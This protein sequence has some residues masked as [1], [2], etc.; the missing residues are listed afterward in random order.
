MNCVAIKNHIDAFFSFESLQSTMTT[1]V[2]IERSEAI[3]LYDLIFG[4]TIII[5]LLKDTCEVAVIQRY[6][7][8]VHIDIVSFFPFLSFFQPLSASFLLFVVR[9]FSLAHSTACKTLCTIYKSQKIF[10]FAIDFKWFICTKPKCWRAYTI[11][12]RAIEMPSTQREK[13]AYSSTNHF[14]EIGHNLQFYSNAI[15]VTNA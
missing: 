1:I 7:L 13:A 5:Q 3:Y 15:P 6:T 9:I 10:A 14:Q 12:T 4:G 11:A 2:P 8:S